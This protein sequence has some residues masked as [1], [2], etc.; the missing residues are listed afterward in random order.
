[1]QAPRQC[2]GDVV[3]EKCVALWW[4]DVFGQCLFLEYAKNLIHAVTKTTLLEFLH[5]ATWFSELHFNIACRSPLSTQ[6]HQDTIDEDIFNLELD[7]ESSETGAEYKVLVAYLIWGIQFF[8]V[9]LLV[10]QYFRISQTVGVLEYDECEQIKCRSFFQLYHMPSVFLET[11]GFPQ[12]QNKK[13]LCVTTTATTTAKKSCPPVL[14]SKHF[15]LSRFCLKR[16]DFSVRTDVFV[17]IVLESFLVSL[18][19]VKSNVRWTKLCR[20]ALSYYVMV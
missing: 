12:K 8:L 15:C 1:M 3:R 14:Y 6:W 18:S 9:P 5:R 16:D 7:N 2:N 17:R 11:H 4:Y 20:R 13:Q 10:P 19:L